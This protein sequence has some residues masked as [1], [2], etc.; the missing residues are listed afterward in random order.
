MTTPRDP[1]RMIRAFLA[2]GPTE[3]ADRSLDA[4]RGEIDRTRQRVVIG[5]WRD[6]RMNAVMKTALAIAAVV[7]VGVVGIN[8]LPGSDGVD[9]APGPTATPTPSPQPTPSPTRPRSPSPTT[10]A[11][12]P[13]GAL[14]VGRYP[15]TLNGIPLSLAVSTTGWRSNGSWG[16]D[17]GRVGPDGAGF[18]LWPTD[19]P[20]G[21]YSDPCGHVK[22]AQVASGSIADLADAVATMPAVELVSGP[23]DVQVGGMAAKLVV[24]R[25]PD[26]IPCAPDEFDLW[27][28]ATDNRYATEAG[29]TYRVW[30]IDAG[31]TTIWIDGETYKGASPEVGNEVEDIVNS[32]QFE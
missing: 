23:T 20:I 15:A 1:D 24:V 22:D 28:S 18:I 25:I 16:L 11:F 3:F 29:E 27:Y 14:A 2:D 7:I 9:G 30:I 5:P 6:P 8:L 26:S 17:K 31:G 32:I 10:A 12:P 4:V 21:V 13:A 19:V